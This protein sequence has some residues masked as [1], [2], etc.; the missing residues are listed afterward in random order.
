M[1]FGQMR[2]RTSMRMHEI[3]IIKPTVRL[4]FDYIELFE[5]RFETS[6]VMRMTGI[7]VLNY[8]LNLCK[9]SRACRTLKE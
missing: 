2:H 1:L 7:A 4:L 5:S 6:S 3:T 8:A 9:N